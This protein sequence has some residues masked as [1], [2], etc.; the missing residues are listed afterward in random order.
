MGKM[1]KEGEQQ[2]LMQRDETAAR[3]LNGYIINGSKI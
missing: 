3:A 1:S 2:N